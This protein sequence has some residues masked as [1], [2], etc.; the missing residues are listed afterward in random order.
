MTNTDDSRQEQIKQ[1]ALD[2]VEARLYDGTATIEE[3][4]YFLQLGGRL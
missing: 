1:A 2:R 4:M 3:T